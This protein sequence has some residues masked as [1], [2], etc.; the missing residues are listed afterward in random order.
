MGR[1]WVLPIIVAGVAAL[2]IA[3]LG[4]TITDLGPWYQGLEKPDW[5][6]PSFVFPIAWTAIFALAALAA[7]S[8]WRAAPNSRVADTVIGLF[9]LNGFLNVLWSLIFFRMQ[10]PDWAFAELMLLWLSVA[11]LILFCARYSRV[12]GL[13]LVPYLVWVTIAG[14]LNWSVVELNGPF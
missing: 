6:P 8:A 7:V 13:A 4:G 11:A 1:S 2:G 10:R 5:S 14:A 3:M 9:A 12:A